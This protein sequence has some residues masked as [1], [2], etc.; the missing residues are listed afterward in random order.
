VF[1]AVGNIYTVTRTRIKYMTLLNAAGKLR[2]RLNEDKNGMSL[3]WA[4][5]RA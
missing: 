1:D 2:G 3:E 4:R 5:G